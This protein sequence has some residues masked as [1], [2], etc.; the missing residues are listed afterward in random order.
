[1]LILLGE[2]NSLLIDLKD[3]V[4]MTV[5]DLKEEIS[6]KLPEFNSIKLNNQNIICAK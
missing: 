5:S 3:D 6:K 4:Q 2:N 1:M